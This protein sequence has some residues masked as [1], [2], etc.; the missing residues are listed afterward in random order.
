[1]LPSARAATGDA[2]AAAGSG[3]RTGSAALRL[4]ASAVCATP[5]GSGEATPS[6]ATP[7][8]A[9]PRGVFRF[10]P[11]KRATPTAEST[12]AHSPRQSIGAG[13]QPVVATPKLV[14][15]PGVGKENAQA[16]ARAGAAGASSTPLPGARARAASAG[17]GDDAHS[18]AGARGRSVGAAVKYVGAVRWPPVRQCGNHPARW[19]LVRG[20]ATAPRGGRQAGMS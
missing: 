7:H 8:I 18:D 15:A 1:M 12:P 17:A 3:G 19:L 13:R 4:A 6:P 2:E 11:P 20:V 5:D 14:L 16:A 9:S 10:S